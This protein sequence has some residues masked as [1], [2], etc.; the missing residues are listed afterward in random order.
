[1]HDSACCKRSL[2]FARKHTDAMKNSQYNNSH[3]TC[4]GQ[5]KIG[6]VAIQT[7]IFDR[8]LRFRIPLN[9]YQ[10]HLVVRLGYGNPLQRLYF[11]QS[12]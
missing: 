9:G 1:M 8:S 2:K 6:A 7:A 3:G 10:V 4:R 12:A 5:Q 11:C